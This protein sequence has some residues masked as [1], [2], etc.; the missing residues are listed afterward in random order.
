MIFNKSFIFLLLSFCSAL[1][2]ADDDTQTTAPDNSGDF[3]WELMFGLGAVVEHSLLEGVHNNEFEDYLDIAILLDMSYKGFYIRSN[4]RRASELFGEIGYELVA[5][6]DWG[7]DIIRKVY[8]PGFDPESITRNQDSPVPMQQG[9]TE[10]MYGGGTALRYSHYQDDAIFTIE[11]AYLDSIKGSNT[12]LIDSFYSHLLPY[13][14]WDFY[15]GA[16]LSFYSAQ[17]NQYFIG[18]APGEVS[19]TRA[20]Y[21]PGAGFRAQLEVLA[22]YP[23]SQGLSFNTGITQSF[24]SDNISDSPLFARQHVTQFMVGL[25]YVY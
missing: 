10:R 16:G 15:L 1:V 19:T 2:L 14:N 3:R 8:I 24:Y 21:Q 22:Q 4:R 18:V 6:E 17:I 25:R 13:R 9:L 20:A 11:A 23:L 5:K 12:W 7:L